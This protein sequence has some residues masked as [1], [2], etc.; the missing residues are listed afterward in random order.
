MKVCRIILQINITKL[1]S[2]PVV[3]FLTCL[4]P[5]VVCCIA[6]CLKLGIV[7][8][9]ELWDEDGKQRMDYCKG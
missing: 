6:E 9:E 4:T 1:F 2:K 7:S 5:C 8:G 3:W